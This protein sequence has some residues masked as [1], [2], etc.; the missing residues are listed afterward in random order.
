[1]VLGFNPQ[2]FELSVYVNSTSTYSSV[3]VNA[4]DEHVDGFVVPSYITFV[5]LFILNAPVSIDV[6]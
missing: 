3:D 1:L 5:K 2:K 4:L 6:I